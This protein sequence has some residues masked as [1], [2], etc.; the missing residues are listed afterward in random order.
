MEPQQPTAQACDWGIGTMGQDTV[1]PRS[2]T[3]D[4]M[5]IQQLFCGVGHESARQLGPRR[6]AAEI[7]TNL[8]LGRL[9]ERLGTLRQ[10]SRFVDKAV[11][12]LPPLKDAFD[13]FVL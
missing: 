5:T 4:Y 10:R 3:L 13:R 9:V 2:T 8:L 11:E 12:L 7:G 1:G 6:Q